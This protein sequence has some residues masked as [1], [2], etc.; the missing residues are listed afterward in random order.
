MYVDVQAFVDIWQK[1]L[2]LHLSEKAWHMGIKA[3]F[4]VKG[5]V[6]YVF[7]QA[8][9]ATLLLPVCTEKITSTLLLG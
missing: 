9:K 7:F 8:V 1:S 4:M 3:Q 6:T 2:N 5:T